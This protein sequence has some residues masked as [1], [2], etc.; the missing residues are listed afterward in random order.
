M[1]RRTQPGL[2]LLE[3]SQATCCWKGKT[4]QLAWSVS[5]DHSETP[6]RH[7]PAADAPRTSSGHSLRHPRGEGFGGRLHRAT[8]SCHRAAAPTLY[9]RGNRR[10]LFSIWD[11]SLSARCRAQPP[12]EASTLVISPR[13]EYTAQLERTSPLGQGRPFPGT[14]GKH[15]EGKFK[16]SLYLK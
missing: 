11:S 12:E 6:P 15:R 1:K 8:A 5:K 10:Q 7:L 14:S 3:G 13:P 16:A 9:T 2:R 4:P